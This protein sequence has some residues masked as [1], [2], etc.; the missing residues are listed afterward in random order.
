MNLTR[1]WNSCS[2]FVS[3][4]PTAESESILICSGIQ[5]FIVV[6]PAS[7]ARGEKE[8]RD[9]FYGARINGG[10]SL[11]FAHHDKSRTGKCTE[12]EEKKDR[13]KR[14]RVGHVLSPGKGSGKEKAGRRRRLNV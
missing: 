4:R 9:K 2:S 7:A 14:E 3:G 12:N 5:R 11:Q 13:H 10:L 6:F 1:A 8:D